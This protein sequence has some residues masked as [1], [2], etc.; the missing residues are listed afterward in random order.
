MVEFTKVKK[1]STK[2]FELIKITQDVRDF[3]AQELASGELME[4]KFEEPVPGRAFLVVTDE[5]SRKSLAA[6]ALLEM[7]KDTLKRG[8]IK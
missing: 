7:M 4:L 1:C 6:A 3:A 5:R 2:E 8:E